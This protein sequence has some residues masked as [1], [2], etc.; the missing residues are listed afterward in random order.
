MIEVLGLIAIGVGIGHLI[1]LV[2]VNRR[3]ADAEAGV[4]IASATIM[5]G[6]QKANAAIASHAADLE[7]ANEDLAELLHNNKVRSL[8]NFV[9]MD[10]LIDGNPTDLGYCSGVDDVKKILVASD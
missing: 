5:A 2:I 3:V 10:K 1:T 6:L 8:Q 4:R 7:N 9:D